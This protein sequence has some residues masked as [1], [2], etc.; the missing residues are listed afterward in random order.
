MQPSSLAA[1]LNDSP[2]HHDHLD[3]IEG[4]ATDGT[5]YTIEVNLVWDDEEKQHIRVMGDLSSGT[6]G[7]LFGFIPV[8][9]PD[10]T[11]DFIIAPDGSTVG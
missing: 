11:D 8:F 2:H 9:T 4:N 6:R 1:R 3:V 10:A 5:E 7:C